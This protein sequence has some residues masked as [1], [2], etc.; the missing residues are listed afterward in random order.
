MTSGSTRQTVIPLALL[1]A[2]A[3]VLFSQTFGSPWLMDDFPVIV[4]NPAIVSFRDFIEHSNFRRLLREVSII[5]DYRLFGLKP[6]GYHIQQIFWHG[7]NAALLFLLALRI[8]CSRV[9]A[10]C[11]ALLFLVHPVTVEVVANISHRKDSIALAFALISLLSY[12]RALSR[13]GSL[14]LWL[15][16]SLISM[17]LGFLAKGNCIMLP[18]LFAVCELA[19]FPPR[20]RLILRHAVWQKRWVFPALAL[21]ALTGLAVWYRHIWNSWDFQQTLVGVMNKM[22]SYDT[23]TPAS[24][25]YMVLKSAAFLYSKIVWPTRLTMEY[26]YPAPVSWHDP[27]VLAGLGFYVL[28]LAGPIMALRRSPPL[29]FAAAWVGLFA[30]PT[31]NIVWP[32]AYFSAD[33]YLYTP[34]AGIALL[35]GMLLARLAERHRTASL[36]LTAAAVILLSALTW[37]QTLVWG[38]E[39]R[40]F[41]TML[42]INPR[43]VAGL[44]NLSRHYRARGD[45]ERAIELMRRAVASGSLKARSNS[46]ELYSD[47]G[48]L[49]SESGRAA[50]AE[51]AFREGIAFNPYAY[52]LHLNLG[53]LLEQQDRLEEAEQSLYAADSAQPDNDMVNYNLGVIQYRRGRLAPAQES[54]AKAARANPR[55]SDALYNLAQVAAENGD[56]ASAGRAL[57]A[58]RQLDPAQAAELEKSLGQPR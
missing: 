14:P 2:A 15:A 20:Q 1:M 10:W 21:A 36:G 33:R 16:A 3:Y 11:A 44:L 51:A 35:A 37:R 58:L 24:Y 49:L 39:E 26:A 34:L 30:L 25:I 41:G 29:F 32:L 45:Y 28:L 4:D 9:A 54:F 18:A 12:H 48:S 7:L 53:T 19:F 55:N 6:A 40:F 43:S 8:G 5:V 42:E 57:E 38:S 56:A 13:A 31:A 23:M 46:A 22:D 47:L 17:L 52:R 50:E 27:W